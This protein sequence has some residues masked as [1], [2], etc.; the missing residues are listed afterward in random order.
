MQGILLMVLNDLR[1]IDLCSFLRDQLTIGSIGILEDGIDQVE[2]FGI[3][4]KLVS[5]LAHYVINL[6]FELH[7]QI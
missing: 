7:L 6:L 1:V 2:L 3:L 5:N 4:V